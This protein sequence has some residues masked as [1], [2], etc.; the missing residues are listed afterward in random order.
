MILPDEDSK[1]AVGRHPGPSGT[2]HNGA[3]EGSS[4]PVPMCTPY[5]DS[6]AERQEPLPPYTPRETEP[7]LPGAGRARKRRRPNGVGLACK[8]LPLLLASAATCAL[9]WASMRAS[10]RYDNEHSTQRV[11]DIFI[12]S[13]TTHLFSVRSALQP[14][15][16]YGAIARKTTHG[17]TPKLACPCHPIF[18]RSTCLLYH[19]GC[20]ALCTFWRPRNIG[21]R[22]SY[23]LSKRFTPIRRS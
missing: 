7:L 11:S 10:A 4:M 2:H 18:P 14:I 9:T 21:F 8:C 19:P 6:E 13:R 16:G 23:L 12:F 20:L 3:P 1:T 5:D 17:F 22:A 15:V